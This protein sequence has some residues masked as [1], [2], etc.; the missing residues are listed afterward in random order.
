MLI[1]VAVHTNNTVTGGAT[2]N[3]TVTSTATG[4]DSVTLGS[5]NN[6]VS[7]G[8]GVNNFTATSGNNTYTGGTGVDTVTVGGG[9]NTINVGVDTAA[10]MV[11]FSATIANGN[12][13]STISNFASGDSINLAALTNT[14]SVDAVAGAFGAKITLAGTAVFQDYLGC[15]N[16]RYYCWYWCSCC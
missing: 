16:S 7:L 10:D 4:T 5:G 9:V 1:W 15:S 2:G 14:A 6:T 12:S 3:N 8:N 11:V 13:Y